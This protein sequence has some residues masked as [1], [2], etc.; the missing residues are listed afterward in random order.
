MGFAVLPS[1]NIVCSVQTPSV[2]KPADLSDTG[3]CAGCRVWNEVFS[4][5]G[6]SLPVDR[7]DPRWYKIPLRCAVRN[8]AHN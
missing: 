6:G 1:G 4:A 3:F 2:L 5:R 8:R 7:R